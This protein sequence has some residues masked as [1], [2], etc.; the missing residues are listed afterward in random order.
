M[1]SNS[2]YPLIKQEF[3]TKEK[4]Y[5]TVLSNKET[6]ERFAI[7]NI[8]DPY[9]HKIFT[10]RKI[11]EYW[12][13]TD[14]DPEILQFWGTN[15]RRKHIDPLYW[16]N[17]TITKARTIA[18]ELQAGYI[19]IP[20]TRFKNEADALHLNG[21]YY[22]KVVRTNEHGGQYVSSDRDPN[23]SSEI[24]LQD[25]PAD[26]TL[27]AFNVDELKQQVEKLY[28]EFLIPLKAVKLFN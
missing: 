11:T 19:L 20:D 7:S 28:N 15:F 2:S 18:N 12:G 14:K 1:N 24:D 4:T 5:Y 26:I 13:M 16:I 9:L 17:K 10:E 27:T 25:Y 3:V 23:H 21:G 6:G 8:N 22:I